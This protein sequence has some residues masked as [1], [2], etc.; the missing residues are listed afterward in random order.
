MSK[1]G[2]TVATINS[3]THVTTPVALAAN[4][5]KSVLGFRAPA[6]FG[7]EIKKIRIGLY[8][9]S[10]SAVPGDIELCQATFAANA[11]GTASTAVTPQ[12]VYGRPIPPGFTAAHTWTA[13]PTV[14]SII[15]PYPIT[16]N[17]GLLVYDLP[18]GDSP[19]CA[20]ST[21]FVLRAKFP[22]AV[23]VSACMWVERI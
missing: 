13:E 12:Q 11:P 8:G 23:S 19:D 5:A 3:T 10:A 2:Y 17:G 16:P 6:E 4:V 18:L 15:D 14:L 7:L 22:A 9:V 21:G 20:P 1:T